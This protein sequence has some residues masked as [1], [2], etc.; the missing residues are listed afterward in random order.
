M[1][2]FSDASGTIPFDVT[3]LNFKVKIKEHQT[4]E[5]NGTVTENNYIYFTN[6]LSGTQMKI[7]DDFYYFERYYDDNNFIDTEVTIEPF[8]Y[9]II[10]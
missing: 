10:N 4:N 5:N 9:N 7:L 3:G 8:N 6:N 1:N 2:F